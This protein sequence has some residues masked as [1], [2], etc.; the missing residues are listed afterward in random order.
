MARV[1]LEYENVLEQNKTLWEMK[2]WSDSIKAMQMNTIVELDDLL[3]I[4]EEQITNK[5]AQIVLEREKFGLAN[6]QIKK[7]R[8]L[9]WVFMGTTVVMA[10]FL[11]LSLF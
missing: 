10:G 6:D 7:E 3:R 9:K 2:V 4:K 8:R 11:T 5:D 1:L